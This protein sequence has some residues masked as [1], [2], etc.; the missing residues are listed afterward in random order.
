MG[1]GTIEV[2]TCSGCNNEFVENIVLCPICALRSFERRME[3]I[4]EEGAESGPRMIMPEPVSSLFGDA[5]SVWSQSRGSYWIIGKDES[6]EITGRDLIRGC[7]DLL[8]EAFYEVSEG[9]VRYEQG[10]ISP[11]K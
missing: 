5:R 4:K 3:D 7:H 2:L 6:W 10:F 1:I 9:A 11:E 8:K